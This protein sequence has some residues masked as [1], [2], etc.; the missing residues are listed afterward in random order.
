ML[1][2]C[3][4]S[5][6]QSQL[7]PDSGFKIGAGIAGYTQEGA[8]A[9]SIMMAFNKDFFPNTQIEINVNWITPVD[10]SNEEETRDLQSFLFGM[11]LL[12]KVLEDRKQAFNA[13][14]GFT[15]GFYDTDWTILATEEQG[16]T[17]EFVPGFSAIVEYDFIL[18][19]YWFFGLRASISR[20]DADKSSWF[21]GGTLGYRF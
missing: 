17:T 7:L 14:L 2:C 9:P 10:V 3:Q 4:W 8:T 12:F 5:I 21:L 13:G 11:N 15:A 19:S 18:P 6:A 16:N 1:L 20:F